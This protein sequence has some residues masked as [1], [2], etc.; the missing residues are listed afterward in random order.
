MLKCLEIYQ[1]PYNTGTPVS[2]SIFLM[3]KLRHRA[4]NGLPTVTQLASGTARAGKE[5]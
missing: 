5:E 4:Y 2:I 3:E 1:Q